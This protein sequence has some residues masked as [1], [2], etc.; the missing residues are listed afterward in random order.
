MA[1]TENWRVIGFLWLHFDAYGAVGGFAGGV[2]G[3]L[4]ALNESV[5]VVFVLTQLGNAARKGGVEASC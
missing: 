3:H 2:E 1:W 4:G 5:E